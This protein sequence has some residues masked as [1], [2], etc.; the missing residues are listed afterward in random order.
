M[1]S[2]PT[3]RFRR[4]VNAP[5]KSACERVEQFSTG[6]F[7]LALALK[8]SVDAAARDGGALSDPPAAASARATA[9]TAVLVPSVVAHR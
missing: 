6:T 5:G 7:R 9:V 8:P 2:G 1:A 3:T 4:A